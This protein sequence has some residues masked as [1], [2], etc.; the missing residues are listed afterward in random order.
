[1]FIKFD[2]SLNKIPR[3]TLKVTEFA[4][5]LLKINCITY[6][7]FYTATNFRHFDVVD[8]IRTAGRANAVRPGSFWTEIQHIWLYVL[9][10]TVY[11][12]Q[13]RTSGSSS[14]GRMSCQA[15]ESLN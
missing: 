2:G 9:L 1:M 3:L 5:F 10:Y 6:Y 4:F 12:L 11:L 7:D 14:P 13:L 8:I 15:D